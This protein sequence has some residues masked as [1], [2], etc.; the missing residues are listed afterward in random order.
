M[1]WFVFIVIGIL[2][3][4]ILLLIFLRR[5]SASQLYGPPEQNPGE[6][7]ADGKLVCT[8][9]KAPTLGRTLQF[10]YGI[11]LTTQA[12]HTTALLRSP[13][14]T[15]K[16]PVYTREIFITRQ[17]EHVIGR[18]DRKYFEGKLTSNSGEL[19]VGYPSGSLLH[20]TNQ[21]FQF[22]ITQGQVE[23]LQTNTSQTVIHHNSRLAVENE[24]IFGRLNHYRESWFVAVDVSFTAV[25]PEMMVLVV[26][27]LANDTLD[28][29]HDY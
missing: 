17:G 14:D 8:S 25:P 11:Q 23:F 20:F 29:H 1:I 27:L 21:P 9:W 7:R 18:T 19:S 15:N 5:Q 16:N 10:E 12:E 13:G 4:I 6:N 3:C 24:R 28:F 26:L 2:L 22:R